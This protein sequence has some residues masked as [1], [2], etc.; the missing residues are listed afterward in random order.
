[1]RLI[2]FRGRPPSRHIAMVWRKSSAMH[3]F[4]GEFADLFRRLPPHL[5]DPKVQPDPG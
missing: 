4:L 1:V 3:G 2:Q 5:L